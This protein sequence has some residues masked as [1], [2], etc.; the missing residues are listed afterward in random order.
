MVHDAPVAAEAFATGDPST[1]PLQLDERGLY[2]QAPDGKFRRHALATGQLDGTYDLGLDRSRRIFSVVGTDTRWTYLWSTSNIETTSERKQ[3]LIAIDFAH[4]EDR[5]LFSVSLDAAPR[6]PQLV[7]AE[8]ITWIGFRENASL[9]LVRTDKQGGDA[10][11]LISRSHLGPPVQD[12]YY[13]YWL[14]QDVPDPRQPPT[15]A[16]LVSMPKRGGPLTVLAEGLPGA[17]NARLQLQGNRILMS[18][19]DPA[20]G[21]CDRT[22]LALDRTRSALLALAR[23]PTAGTV[24]AH[25]RGLLWQESTDTSTRIFQVSGAGAQLLVPSTDRPVALLGT[26]GNFFYWHVDERTYRAP[27]P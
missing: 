12:A 26:E 4:P 3:E 13:L 27:L 21:P 23:A 7:D 22:I 5:T 25:P 19:N 10:R 18:V 2:L 15:A 16:R 24:V 20:G 8:S 1:Y 17:T 9:D 6:I 14:E 11:T